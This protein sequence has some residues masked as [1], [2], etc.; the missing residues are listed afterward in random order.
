MVIIINEDLSLIL[1]DAQFEAKI[2]LKF[3]WSC[4]KYNIAQ[5]TFIRESQCID[6]NK[7]QP[8][9]QMCSIK[10]TWGRVT[11]LIPFARLVLWPFR[12]VRRLQWNTLFAKL[13]D[14]AE[15]IPMRLIKPK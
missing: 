10:G 7:L 6:P 15:K 5:E 3:P 4:L 1:Y 2:L 12:W 9:A 11:F 8:G 14:C 13:T